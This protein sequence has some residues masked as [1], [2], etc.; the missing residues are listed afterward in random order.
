MKKVLI[1]LTSFVFIL[2]ACGN[3]D[4]KSSD[5]VITIALKDESPTNETTAK[6]FETLEKQ[7]NEEYGYD[8]KLELVEMPAGS[9]ADSLNLKIT[10]GEIPDLMYFQGGDVAMVE[11]DVLLDLTS[12]VDESKYL[13]DAMQEHSKA[14]LENYPYLVYLRPVSN[15]VPVISTEL[16]NSLS[17]Y[18]AL[19]ADPSI[20]NYKA[21]FTEINSKGYESGITSAG[22]LQEL[23][24]IFNSAFGINSTWVEQDGELVNSYITEETK[25]KLA[26]YQELYNAKM[27]D[28]AYLTTEWDVK[29]DKFYSG[30]TGVIVGSSP[31][32][33]NIYNTK[34]E[35]V[36]GSEL[37]ILPP[38]SSS[39]GSTYSAIDNS[40]ESRGFAISS[41]SKLQKETFD[42]LDFLASPKGQTLDRLGLE[43]V[44]YNVEGDTAVFTEKHSEWFAKFFE[45][46][47][48]ELEYKLE[49]NLL[50]ATEQSTIDMMD[51]YYL[52]DNN[53]LI[54]NDLS[55]DL[56][57]S[58]NVYNEFAA[59]VVTGKKSI[60]EFDTFVKEYLNNGGQALADYVNK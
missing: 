52:E 16:A 57:A 39:L 43:G 8:V 28:N 11:Q 51:Q 53:V 23:D 48:T 30:K 9:Y 33:I 19:S 25:N 4:S 45:V 46:Q 44:H 47:N 56:D 1:V 21:L 17:S 40:K 31:A 37:Q 12:Y 15:G 24:K 32:I 38:A 5:N 13:K 54:P 26:F 59:D 55:A 10:S 2:S 49:D 3:K 6:Y 29:E 42:L 20:D 58:T 27:L 41:Q 7:F 18:S 14:R 60:S 22:S 34:L 35:N 50:S 36:S